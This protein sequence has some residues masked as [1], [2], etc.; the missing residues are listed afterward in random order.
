MTDTAAEED[1]DP[2]IELFVKVGSCLSCLFVS[3]F[4]PIQPE[5]GRCSKVLQI[6]A[7]RV[8]VVVVVVC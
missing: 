3:I 8:V 2:D 4:S 5:P 6:P 7:C 1:K